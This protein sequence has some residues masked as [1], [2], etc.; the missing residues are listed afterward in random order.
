M[1]LWHEEKCNADKIGHEELD[2]GGDDVKTRILDARAVNTCN[3]FGDRD[4]WIL[5]ILLRS[6]RM[7][8]DCI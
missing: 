2:D 3:N 5:N 6:R 1:N 4:S 8:V 7:Y